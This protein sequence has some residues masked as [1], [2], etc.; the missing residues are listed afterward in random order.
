VDVVVAVYVEK[1]LAPGPHPMAV[2]AQQR[3]LGED[4]VHG[5]HGHPGRSRFLDFFRYHVGT[6]V[7]EPH[8]GLMDRQPLVGG[9]QAM[10][11]QQDTEL[12]HVRRFSHLKSHN[13]TKIHLIL[14]NSKWYHSPG[15]KI[16]KSK[17]NDYICRLYKK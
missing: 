13:G 1:H 2:N 10:F 8:H 5:R 12:I 7:T 11:F 15:V 16:G 17:S 3:Q 6:G 9:F 14:N 4:I